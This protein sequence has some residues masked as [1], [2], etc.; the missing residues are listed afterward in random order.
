MGRICLWWDGTECSYST[1]EQGESDCVEWLKEHDAA[2][3]RTATLKTLEATKQLRDAAIRDY[4]RL[5]D[6]EILGMAS[7]Y[8]KVLKLLGGNE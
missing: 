6:K 3:A 2:I 4:E 7:A 5:Q 8:T 1:K